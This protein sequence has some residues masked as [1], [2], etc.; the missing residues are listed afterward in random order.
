LL[1]LGKILRLLIMPN[2]NS[3]VQLNRIIWQNRSVFFCNRLSEAAGSNCV[4]CGIVSVN[5]VNAIDARCGD[6]SSHAL[7]FA[8]SI[9]LLVKNQSVN[10][11][12]W[13]V[14][15]SEPMT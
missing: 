11:R 4:G 5:Q 3:F 9:D 10:D 15:G 6:Q 13:L 2:G 14:K 8:I 1:E 7:A 12:L